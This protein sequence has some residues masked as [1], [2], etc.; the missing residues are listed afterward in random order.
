MDWLLFAS[1]SMPMARGVYFR[2]IQAA[3][4]FALTLVFE[5]E[6][7]LISFTSSVQAAEEK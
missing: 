5:W 3:R 2:L 6:Q 7:P 1:F 4:P